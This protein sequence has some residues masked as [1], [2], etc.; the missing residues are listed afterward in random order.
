[1]TERGVSNHKAPQSTISGSVYVHIIDAEILPR[2]Q[3][4]LSGAV[5]PDSTDIMLDHSGAPAFA[6]KDV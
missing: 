1:M 3:Y 2:T 5:T 4:D 6:Q